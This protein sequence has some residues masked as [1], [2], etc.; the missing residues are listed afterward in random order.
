MRA[1]KEMESLARKI[2]TSGRIMC[3]CI[4][5]TFHDVRE[6]THISTSPIQ[7][8]MVCTAMYGLYIRDEVKSMAEAWNTANVDF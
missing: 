5:L 3:Y 7:P 4:Q 6:T 2:A 1:L 8:C